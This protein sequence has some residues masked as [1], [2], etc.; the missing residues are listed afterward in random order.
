VGQPAAL[1]VPAAEEVLQRVRAKSSPAA[2]WLTNILRSATQEDIHSAAQTAVNGLQP[3]TKRGLVGRGVLIDFV[4]YAEKN[5]LQ[6]SHFE[7]FAITLD[8]VLAIAA[9]QKLELHTGD[10]LFLRTGFTTAYKTLDHDQRRDVASRKEWCGLVKAGKRQSGFG[11][12]NSQP[13]LATRRGSKSS[14]SRRTTG[15]SLDFEKNADLS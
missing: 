9:E 3:W 11:S 13:W 1:C 8:Q 10:I 15:V 7:G 14:V 2:L 5:G 6:V 12:D 4:S